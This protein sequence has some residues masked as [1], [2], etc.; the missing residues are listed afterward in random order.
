MKPRRFNARTASTPL[1]SR[2]ILTRRRE[3]GLGRN[4]AGCAWAVVS[5]RSNRQR[6][7][8]P[9]AWQRL[10]L[11]PPAPERRLRMVGRTGGWRVASSKQSSK[12][13]YR[14]T[15]AMVNVPLMKSEFSSATGSRW[16][17]IPKREDRQVCLITCSASPSRY[18]CP[19]RGLAAPFVFEEIC[20]SR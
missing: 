4:A 16:H 18:S 5:A 7:R 10:S 12:G 8:Q 6:H 13:L 9:A 17:I 11:M 19:R 14:A 15:G 2:G 1:T 3:S 20:L